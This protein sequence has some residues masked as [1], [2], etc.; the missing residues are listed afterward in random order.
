MQCRLS[1]TEQRVLKN[2]KRQDLPPMLFPQARKVKPSIASL[3]PN[4]IPNV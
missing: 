2:E 3:K 4:T 1:S